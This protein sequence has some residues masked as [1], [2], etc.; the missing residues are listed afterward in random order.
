M[1]P[2]NCAF[3]YQT[4]PTSTG[5]DGCQTSHWEGGGEGVGGWG[6]GGEGKCPPTVQRGGLGTRAREILPGESEQDGLC[7]LAS[8]PEYVQ[9]REG[10]ASSSFLPC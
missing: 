5:V 4:I 1:S 9:W 8:S 2:F 7:L 10:V 3:S 6:G